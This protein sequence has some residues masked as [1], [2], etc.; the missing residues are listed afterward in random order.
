VRAGAVK[1]GAPW[2]LGCGADERWLASAQ[3]VTLGREYFHL[4][5]DCVR[6][7]KE[8]QLGI[9]YR[10]ERDVVENVGTTTGRSG[11]WEI[12]TKRF[13]EQFVVED[14]PAA[15]AGRFTMFKSEK[16][17]MQL[18]SASIQLE[19]V[20]KGEEQ[21]PIAIL[22]LNCQLTKE[23]TK[24]LGKST[25]AHCY[26]ED[27]EIRKDLNRVSL[28]RPKRKLQRVTCY[29]TPDSERANVAIPNV[30][31]TE[32]AISRLVL[33]RK[34]KEDQIKLVA[35]L[36]CR[37]DFREKTMR[38]WLAAHFGKRMFFSF[39]PEQV[40]LPMDDD[41]VEKNRSAAK[42]AVEEKEN[43]KEKSGGPRRVH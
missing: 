32:L 29:L 9:A 23:L 22:A 38:D 24:E 25:F 12:P 3:W 27:G 16:V 41:E 20:K 8:R 43:G 5:S 17:P 37:V 39:G 10:P 7:V 6:A 36:K 14:V 19:R 4:C 31:C 1:I 42:K 33:K 34:G 35:S 40:D 2:C 15:P 18:A 21:R 28:A 26:D 11:W 13:E 30:S